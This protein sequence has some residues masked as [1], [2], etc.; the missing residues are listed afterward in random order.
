MIG[1][2]LSRLKPSELPILS[3]K[4]D[5]GFRPRPISQEDQAPGALSYTEIF[6]AK[7]LYLVNNCLTTNC[8]A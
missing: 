7:T 4:K 2:V 1:C 6:R 3:C 8:S 5:L